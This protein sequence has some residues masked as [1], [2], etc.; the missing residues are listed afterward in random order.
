METK[1]ELVNLIKSQNL[2]DI[3]VPSFINIEFSIDNVIQI[4]SEILNDI[5]KTRPSIGIIIEDSVPIE[6]VN[7]CLILRY[8]KSS[9]FNESLFNRA[10]PFIQKIMFKYFNKN[11]DLRILKNQ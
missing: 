2:I 5:N 4:W 8:N 7:N 10:I 1:K 3:R 11:I 9:G 6:I